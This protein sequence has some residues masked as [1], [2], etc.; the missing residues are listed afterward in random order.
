MK[1]IHKILSLIIGSSAYATP[2]PA[3]EPAYT[4]IKDVT[5]TIV[6]NKSGTYDFKSVLHVWKGKN[7]GCNQNENGPQLLRVEASNVVVKN[8]YYA[9]DGRSHGSNGVG[10]PIHIASCGKGQGNL[11][12]GSVKNV[13]LDNIYG[14]A[15]EDMIT[16]GTPG[17]DNITIQNSVLR[18]NPN[19]KYIDKTVQINFGTR[20][21]FINNRFVGGARCI[22]FKPNTSGSVIGNVFE[23]CGPPVLASSNS[24]DI[25]PMKNGPITVEM[26]QNTYTK[27]GTRLSCNGKTKFNTDGV[28]TC[29]YP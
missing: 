22:L 28:Y 23:G 1:K 11:C 26:R 24:A 25:K 29:K 5:A 14:H 3:T 12:S 6:I 16:I 17:N 15:C 19:P 27:W 18:T 20:I 9:A 2:P 7:W 10:D 21:N 13:T 4:A 8:F